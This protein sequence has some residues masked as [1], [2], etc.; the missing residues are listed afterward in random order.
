MDDI[1]VRSVYNEGFELVGYQLRPYEKR[2]YTEQDYDLLYFINVEK[3]STPTLVFDK[4][5]KM[6][7]KL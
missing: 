2:V 6:N 3:F 5:K 1:T 4:L 7:C